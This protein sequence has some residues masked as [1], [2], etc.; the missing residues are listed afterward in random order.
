[1]IIRK[2]FKY[3]MSHRVVNA[4]TKR[5]SQNI[6][7]HSYKLE[8]LFI[9]NAPDQ[10]QM[11]LDFG[12]VKKYFHPFVDAFD[13]AHMVWDCKE[14]A[15]EVDY[16]T[17]T[18]ARWITAPFSSTAEMQAKMFFTYGRAALAQL[19]KEG[20]VNTGA[21]M[22]SAIVHETDTGY[23]QYKMCDEGV[24]QFPKVD[25]SSINFSTGITEE[26]APEFKTFYNTLLG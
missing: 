3:E 8:L 12:F 16:I 22:F 13:H 4:Y 18:N 25:L 15:G 1:M 5:C 24:C 11:V 7:G 17:K 20:I 2:L 14:R 10:A 26:W 21:E 9:G 6:H 19:K 23:A